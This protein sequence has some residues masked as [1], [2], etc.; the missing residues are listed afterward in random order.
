M[1]VRQ[2]ASLTLAMW[3]AVAGATAQ[4]ATNYAVSGTQSYTLDSVTDSFANGGLGAVLTQNPNPPSFSGSWTIDLATG[5]LASG[6]YFK[7]YSMKLDMTA[8]SFGTVD[9]TVPNRELQLV[10]G[11]Y[12]YS[13]ATRTIAITHGVFVETS[14][15]LLCDDG[16]TFF[17]DAVPGPN[18]PS[19]GDLTLTFAPDLQ[20]FTGVAH[21]YQPI[22]LLTQDNTG[23][24]IAE[25]GVNP[26]ANNTLTF[27]GTAVPVPA[28][29]W[30]FGSSVLGLAGMRR[31]KAA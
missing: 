26:C 10:G 4:A 2:I 27:S 30:L 28:A 3:C 20:S 12:S 16:G 18:D 15:G 8:A 6:F 1:K 22:T 9:L 21:V 5:Q 13:A 14:L 23:I 31:R 29:A 19:H 11:I 7:P 24:C 17:C 25:N